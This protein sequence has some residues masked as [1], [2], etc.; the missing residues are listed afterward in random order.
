MKLFQ[1]VQHNFATL[2]FVLHPS[3]QPKANSINY[4]IVW[5]FFLF[6]FTTISYVMFAMHEASR[7]IEFAVPIIACLFNVV[8]I[9]CYSTMARKL[10]KLIEIVDLVENNIDGEKNERRMLISLNLLLFRLF[11][12]VLEFQDPTMTAIY[13]RTNRQIESTTKTI[14][15]F[16]E[17]DHRRFCYY[18]SFWLA[19]IGILALIWDQTHL[20]YEFRCG[21]YV[22]FKYS[23]NPFSFHFKRMTIDQL[24]H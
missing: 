6:G 11:F 4:K 2:G 22:E 17:K 12:I 16:W 9:V 19:F 20:N 1:L 24:T 10:S 8:M 5:G 3:M 14:C 18:H 21:K 15:S 23:P 7:F 13:I